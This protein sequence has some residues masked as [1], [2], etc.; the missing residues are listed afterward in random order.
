[1]KQIKRGFT[2]AEVLITLGIIG[3]VAAITVPALR[4]NTSSDMHKAVLLKT[5]KQ[6][7]LG[8]NTILNKVNSNSNTAG[9]AA[10]LASITLVDIFGENYTPASGINKT[11]Y[12][13]KEDYIFRL[14][15]A[16]TTANIVDNEDYLNSIK[17][18]SG[19]DKAFE[20]ITGLSIFQLNGIPSY[21]IYEETPEDTITDYYKDHKDYLQND[22]VVAN[23]YIDVN[24]DQ[25]PNR[26][27]KD[28]LMFGLTNDGK[29][30]PAGSE[31][32][33]NNVFEETVP[34]YTDEDGC[35]SA[36]VGDGSSCAAYVASNGWA[37]KF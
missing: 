31:A 28:I 25:S 10:D 19:N 11:D 7:E 29:L 2:I 33:N 6:V 27:G 20:K 35:S 16:F 24:K 30:V 3:I 14:T 34:L 26:L 13:L 8:M 4:K 36:G 5:V 12:L 23:L 18:Y 37:V 32:Y 22:I 1:M 17:K 21:I 15:R 9:I